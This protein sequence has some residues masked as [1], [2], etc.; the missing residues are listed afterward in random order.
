[1]ELRVS[2]LPEPDERTPV[3]LGTWAQYVLDTCAS[4]EEVMW[5]TRSRH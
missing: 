4:V 2:K 5:N 1:M 3:T